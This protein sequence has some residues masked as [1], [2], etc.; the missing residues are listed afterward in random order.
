L[1]VVLLQ[2][3]DQD[4]DIEATIFEQYLSVCDEGTVDAET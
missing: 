3:D 2:D 1:L 4:A